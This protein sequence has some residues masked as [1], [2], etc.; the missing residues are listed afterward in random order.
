MKIRLQPLPYPD[1]NNHQLLGLPSLQPK[2]ANPMTNILSRTAM[3]A[4]T[5]SAGQPVKRQEVQRKR[6][7]RGG[8]L[9]RETEK[10]MKRIGNDGRG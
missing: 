1:N 5:L 8:K 10:V 7:R 9:R 3:P 4:M 6:T 2:A